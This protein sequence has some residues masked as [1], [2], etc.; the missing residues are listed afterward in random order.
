LDD[1]E[2]GDEPC[3]YEEG[4]SQFV[5]RGKQFGRKITNL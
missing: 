2:S 4:R 5:H 1:G 3:G